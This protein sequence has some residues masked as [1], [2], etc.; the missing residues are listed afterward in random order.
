MLDKIPPAVR[1]AAFALLAALLFWLQDALPTFTTL[2][3]VVKAALAT[4]VTLALAFIT[5]L[6]R[7]Y[8]VGAPARVVDTGEGAAR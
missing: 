7:Q 2:P 3:D 6:T 8:G 4:A 1:H 5:P